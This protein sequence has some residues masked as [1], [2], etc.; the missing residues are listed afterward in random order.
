MAEWFKA[1]P[2]KGCIVN[3]YRGFES[4]LFRQ[5]CHCFNPLKTLLD[6]RLF[7]FKIRKPPTI[8]S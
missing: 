5:Y 2:W 6:D 4:L 1:H 7:L 3:S 8:S